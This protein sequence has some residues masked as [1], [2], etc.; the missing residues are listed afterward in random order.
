MS[1][2]VKYGRWEAKD[3]KRVLKA[4][5]NSDIGLNA[6]SH[7]YSVP[8]A[9]L[10]RHVDGKNYFGVENTQVMVAWRYSPTCGRET[11]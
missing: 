7:K 4:F 10:K 1:K 6:V 5:Q 3:V 8:K 11:S 2:S 9:T